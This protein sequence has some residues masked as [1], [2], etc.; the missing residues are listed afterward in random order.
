MTTP[1]RTS[2]LASLGLVASALTV[3]S[4]LSSPASAGIV[5][6]PLA[7]CT[8]VGPR[9]CI[10]S[11]TRNGDPVAPPYEVQA[12]SFTIDG[13]K[14]VTF[15]A[16]KTGQYDM[17]FAELTAVWAVTVDMGTTV[18]RVVT[19]KGQGVTVT[20]TVP[21]GSHRVTV[22]ARPVTVSGQ[23]DQS[24]WPWTCPE[25]EPAHDPENQQWDSTLD[26]DIT[27]YGV[28]EDVEQRKAMYGMNY[29]TNVAATSV[30]PE[31]SHDGATD[32]DY[33]LIRL[34]NRRFLEDGSTLVHGQAELRIP[35]AFLRLAY[36]VPNPELMT[37]GS[38]SVSGTAGG[39]VSVTQESGDDAMLVDIA[40][41]EFPDITSS[42]RMMARAASSAKLVRVKRGAITPTRPRITKAVRVSGSKGKVVFTKAKPRGAK[43]TGY[44]ARCVRPGQTVTAQGR[45]D[46]ITVTGLTPGKSYKCQVR[47]KSKA[48]PG[49][50][51]RGKSL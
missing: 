7:P 43:V 24:A 23:C 22:V 37:G 1:R 48:G 20:R 39:T 15:A 17:G 4:N 2:L 34:A 30:P 42:P 51:S 28:W 12:Q 10:V 40:S 9:P 46:R 38:L 18:P 45:F 13:S 19:G 25:W 32:T 35:N 27:D 16:T 41:L 36:G 49:R 3:L 11:A 33:L 31:I 44:T 5:T 14:H 50:W 21:G 8:E 29:F 6:T 26:A 47:A